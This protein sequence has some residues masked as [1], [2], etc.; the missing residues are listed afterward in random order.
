MNLR[1][2]LN[3]FSEIGDLL[4]TF[5]TKAEFARFDPRLMGF[6]FDRIKN[7]QV[8]VHEALDIEELD[9]VVEE[10]RECLELY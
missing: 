7:G 6:R 1:W 5:R 2:E 4:P 10:W 8:K 3:Y 9:G